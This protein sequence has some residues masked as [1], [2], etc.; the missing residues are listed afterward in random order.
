MN[1]AIAYAL[2][3][4]AAL[5]SLIEAGVNVRNMIE[6]GRERIAAMQAEGR[7]PTDEEW[8]ELNAEIEALNRRLNSD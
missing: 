8:A 1:A 4:L 5:P 2:Q 6:K 7:D 3:L